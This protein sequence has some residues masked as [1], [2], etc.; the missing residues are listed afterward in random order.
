MMVSVVYSFKFLFVCLDSLAWL[1]LS[2]FMGR[3]NESITMFKVV[4]AMWF[5]TKRCMTCDCHC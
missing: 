5:L 3:E 2:V 4:L 1:L